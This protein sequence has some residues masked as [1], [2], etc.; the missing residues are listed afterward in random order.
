M[1]SLV[2]DQLGGPGPKFELIG[3]NDCHGGWQGSMDHGLSFLIDLFLIGLGGA[4]FPEAFGEGDDEKVVIRRCIDSNREAKIY[5][6][7]N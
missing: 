3:S 5:Q 2:Q 4:V 6:L 7:A 1:R